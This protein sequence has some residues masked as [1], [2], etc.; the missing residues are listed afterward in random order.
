MSDTH[1]S[2]N[3]AADR[4]D[5]ADPAARRD[6][7]LVPRLR[8]VGHHVAGAARRPR[9]PQAGAPP[10]HLG[11]GAAGLPPRPPVRQVRP[12]VGRH[13]GPLPPPRRRRHLRRPR[14]DGPA[15]L[16]APS[17]DRLPRQLRVPRLRSGG[18]R[19]TPS[20]GCTR[21][22][23]SCSTASTRTPST[24]CPTTTAAPSSPRCCPRGSPTCSSTAA[25]ASPSAWPPTSRRTTS[26]R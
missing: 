5:P 26:A 14:A 22:R 8:H 19:A 20:A 17:A 15:V 21:W 13:D 23:C 24:W 11:H 6:G 12:R 10:D 3:D 18:R 7:E 25:R 1:E 4:A 2:P 9:R 16:A